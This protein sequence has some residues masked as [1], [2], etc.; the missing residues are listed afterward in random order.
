MSE[1]RDF[2]E[3]PRRELARRMRAGGAVD[4]AEIEGWTYRGVS[5]GL[6]AWV[7]RLAWKTFAKTFH[8][9]ADTGVLRGWNTRLEQTGLDGPLLPKRRR[10]APFTFGHFHVVSFDGYAMPRPLAN[11]LLLDYGLGANPALDPT[12]AVRDPIVAVDAGRSDLLLGWTYLDLGFA[13]VPTPSYFTL[14][15]CERLDPANVP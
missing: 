2:L 9:D 7:D 1:A 4:P 3:Q 11:G 12:R 10:G 15:R 6:P 13:R 8:R 5:L 14:E